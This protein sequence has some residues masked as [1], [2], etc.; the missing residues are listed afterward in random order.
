M[1]LYA[2]NFVGLE[3]RRSH[4]IIL[5]KSRLRVPIINP[6]FHNLKILFISLYAKI[7]SFGVQRGDRVKHQGASLALPARFSK[8]HW[9]S[10]GVNSFKQS[11]IIQARV[12]TSI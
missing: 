9:V 7:I 12:L 6:I 1:L 2:Y 10:S 5:D 4:L 8:Y 11:N 3:M